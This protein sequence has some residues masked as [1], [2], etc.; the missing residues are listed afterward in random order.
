MVIAFLAIM[1]NTM[2]TRKTIFYPLPARDV[3][4][5]QH[6]ELFKEATKGQHVHS[7]DLCYISK[8]NH[9]HLSNDDAVLLMMTQ[10]S[11]SA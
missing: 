10:E 4:G 3:F 2:A 6:G 7:H 1:K 8:E 5:M 9:Y 11:V